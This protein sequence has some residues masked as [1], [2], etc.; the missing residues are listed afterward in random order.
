MCLRVKGNKIALGTVDLGVS[1][2]QIRRRLIKVLGGG[3]VLAPAAGKAAAEFVDRAKDATQE[4]LKE[5]REQYERL[6]KRTKAI[7]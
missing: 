4:E 1:M 5:L 6:D 2:N 3:L 7:V